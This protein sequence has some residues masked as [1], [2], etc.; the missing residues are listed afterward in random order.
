MSRIGI[1]VTETPVECTTVR[2]SYKHP[3]QGNP[4][5]FNSPCLR[6]FIEKVKS[7]MGG[8]DFSSTGFGITCSELTRGAATA[9]LKRYATLSLLY[10]LILCVKLL[11]LNIGLFVIYCERKRGSLYLSHVSQLVTYSCE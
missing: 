1:V 3:W 7:A 2:V 6:K 11:F 5:S 10:V 9:P 8:E 4:K